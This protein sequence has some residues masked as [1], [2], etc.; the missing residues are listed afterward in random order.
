L[1]LEKKKSGSQRNHLGR[2]DS[3]DGVRWWGGGGGGG[4]GSS[5]SRRDIMGETKEDKTVVVVFIKVESVWPNII[6]VTLGA[7]SL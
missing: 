2:P 6:Y 5:F 4:G 7:P 1:G 3:K